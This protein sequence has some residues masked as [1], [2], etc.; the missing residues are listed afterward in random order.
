MN[1]SQLCALQFYFRIQRSFYPAVLVNS[2]LAIS[3][4][5]VHEDGKKDK[6]LHISPRQGKTFFFSI[7]GKSQGILYQARE[8]LV[9]SQWTVGEFYLCLATRFA[10]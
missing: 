5:R 1:F 7:S 8:V 9:L 4:T 3:H 2:K 10:K 6:M